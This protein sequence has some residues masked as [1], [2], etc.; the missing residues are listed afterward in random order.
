[1][2][3][4]KVQVKILGGKVRRGEKDVS[5]SPSKTTKHWN[6]PFEPFKGH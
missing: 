6:L 4:K 1:M 3:K 2:E 5:L